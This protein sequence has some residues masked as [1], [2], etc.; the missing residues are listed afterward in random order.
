MVSAIDF[1][2]FWE[3]PCVCATGG[4]LADAILQK[5]VQGELFS[6]PEL[7]DLLLQVSMGLK[8]IHSSG[9]VH[10]DIKPSVFRCAVHSFHIYI[11]HFW[12]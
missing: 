9:L 6:E 11:V 10:L 8:Y 5:E 2:W 12:T 4:S 3:P 1:N 7:K